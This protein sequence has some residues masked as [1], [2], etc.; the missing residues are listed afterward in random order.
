MDTSLYHLQ[1][2]SILQPNVLP[3]HNLRGLL[4]KYY[5][6]TVCPRKKKTQIPVQNS[7]TQLIDFY[8]CISS[9]K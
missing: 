4:Y 9:L 6:Y 1:G 8:K 3:I 5:T 7:W 2:G